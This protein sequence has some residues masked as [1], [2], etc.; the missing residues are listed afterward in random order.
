MRKA[1]DCLEDSTPLFVRAG[2]Y[3]Q[4]AQDSERFLHVDV[5]Q[6]VDYLQ[7]RIGD[8]LRGVPWQVAQ[9]RLDFFDWSAMRTF[10]CGHNSAH[11]LSS[12]RGHVVV[13]REQV[14]FH[15]R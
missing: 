1:F 9:W 2:R 8:P 6:L 3:I 5:S 11:Y 4:I 13:E 15:S 14:V 7:P 12:N 10:D